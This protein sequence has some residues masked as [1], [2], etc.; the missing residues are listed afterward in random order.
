MSARKLRIAIVLAETALLGAF[1]PTQWRYRSRIEIPAGA[2]LVSV[3]VAR[4]IYARSR[5][6]LPDLRAVRETEEVPF[7]LEARSGS[8]QE[9]ARDAETVNKEV[10]PGA[11]LR[12][13]LDLGQ[14]I[15]HSRVRLQTP[16]TNFREL[17]RI[18]TSND[19]RSWASVR[20]DAWIFH[21]AQDG[22]SVGVLSIDYPASTRRYVRV[23]VP[24]WRKPDSISGASALYHELRPAELE[25]IA[26][27]KAHA[28]DEPATK[29]TKY[30]FDLG[31]EGLPHDRLRVEAG[32]SFFHRAVELE[33]SKDGNEWVRLGSGVIYRLPGVS[34]ETVIFPETYNR[35]LRL[36]VFNEDNQPVGIALAHISTV[37]RYVTF[38]STTRAPYW[39]FYG[40]PA[41]DRPVYDLGMI[42][43]R[44]SSE[45]V[46]ASVGATE[47]NSAYQPPPEPRKPWTDRY[48]A[49]LYTILGAAVLG[50]GY[51]TLRFLRRV[52]TP[53]QDS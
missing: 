6:G 24:G 26:S 45:P 12:I 16:E 33:T 41:A 42:L 52:M 5:P 25:L 51:V 36:R 38:E 13:T 47:Q 32:Q 30:D 17:V 22:R 27:L 19:N 18:E 1:E 39:L 34:S 11:G 9:T 14:E 35:Y 48:P 37:A 50:M 10:V 44:R 15:K 7:V 21:F 2:E 49:V 31:I 8:T 28:S 46:R 40:N 53:P 3:R 20:E 29:S 23:S 4:D 43:A